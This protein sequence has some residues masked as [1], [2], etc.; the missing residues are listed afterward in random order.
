MTP[1]VSVLIKRN[2]RVK[3]KFDCKNY[4]SGERFAQKAAMLSVLPSTLYHPVLKSG[5]LIWRKSILQHKNSRR[6]IIQ[7]SIAIWGMTLTRL[8]STH[9]NT[10]QGWCNDTLYLCLSAAESSHQLELL[11][12]CFQLHLG[13]ASAPLSLSAFLPYWNSYFFFISIKSCAVQAFIKHKK[14]T[15]LFLFLSL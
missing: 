9:M 13:T 14:T 3:N 7:P 8:V 4:Q 2:V 5:Y 11:S 10:R 12:W 6:K 15:N 1:G